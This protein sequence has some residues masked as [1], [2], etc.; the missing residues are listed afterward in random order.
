MNIT[1]QRLES[2]TSFFCNIIND[3]DI[4]CD[5][6]ELKGI[7]YQFTQKLKHLNILKK[8]EDCDFEDN[9]Y[10]IGKSVRC[11]LILIHDLIQFV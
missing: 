5:S 6:K 8:L 1:Y 3:F 7:C 4:K 9:K 10:K 2:D 11:Y